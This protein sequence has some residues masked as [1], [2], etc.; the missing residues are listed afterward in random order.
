MKS[1]TAWPLLAAL[2]VQG[3][4]AASS[5][6]G[7]ASGSVA[8]VSVACNLP[9]L[10]PSVYDPVCGS[11][12]KTYSNSCFLRRARCD[13]TSLTQ[14]QS[15]ACG[16]S[17]SSSSG[18]IILGSGS[19]SQSSAAVRVASGSDSGS[20]SA[21]TPSSSSSVSVKAGGVLAMALCGLA[22]VAL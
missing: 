11:D 19:G 3:A 6:S 17:S 9:I 1:V 15:S 8:T 7:S 2:A 20:A 22:A 12:G 21:V 5:A 14:V 4:M 18:S 10:C 13:D 16:S